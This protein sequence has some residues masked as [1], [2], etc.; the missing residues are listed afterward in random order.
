MQPQR[1]PS[2]LLPVN[3]WFVTIQ[4]EATWTGTPSLFVRLQGCPVGCGWCDTKYTWPQP[5]DDIRLAPLTVWQAGDKEGPD[6]HYAA[7]SA[8]TLLREKPMNVRHVVITG[9]EPCQYDLTEF[10]AIL[11]ANGCTTQVETSGTFA[12]RV[13]PD[14]WVTLSPKLDMAGGLEVR[15]DAYARANEV[16][17]PVGKERDLAVLM[18]RVLPNVADGVPVWLQ[19]LSQSPS[20]TKLC[21]RAAME[22]GLRVSVQTHKYLGVR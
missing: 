15:P 2:T 11:H 10:T 12:V 17:F 19:P 22:L 3:E 5:A 21:V 9:G 13:S 7:A 1:P 16:K 18:D 6:H 20:A 14:T 4:G 8:Y